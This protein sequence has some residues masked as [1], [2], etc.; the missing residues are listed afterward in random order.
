VSAHDRLRALLERRGPEGREER[1][2]VQ[3]RVAVAGSD[4]RA[5]D[6]RAGA[7]PAVDDL[8]YYLSRDHRHID[9]RDEQCLDVGS[10]GV[11]HPHPQRGQLTTG[12]IGVFDKDREPSGGVAGDGPGTGD[13][14]YGNAYKQNA[15][16]VSFGGAELFSP[17]S[18]SA[19]PITAPTLPGSPTNLQATAAGNN[20]I[21]LTWANGGGSP[22]GIKI[23]RSMD[24]LSFVAVT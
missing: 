3:H 23:E 18:T 5:D 4:R 2:V 21:S 13:G 20:Q 14:V 6:R 7:P 11:V 10:D 19:N 15:W 24:G 22:T 9:Q 1:P 12:W 16:T 17:W 8:A